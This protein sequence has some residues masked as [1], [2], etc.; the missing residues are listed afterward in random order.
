MIGLTSA[1]IFRTATAAPRA[2]RRH[3]LRH[4]RLVCALTLAPTQMT[5]LAATVAMAPPPARARLVPTARTAATG[6]MTHLPSLR[7]T[8][9]LRLRRRSCA[10]T[11][12]L[13][14][15]MGIAAMAASPPMAALTV[16]RRSA[17]MVRI[18]RTAVHACTLLRRRH[19]PNR[20]R[21]QRRLRLRLRQHRRPH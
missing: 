3:R 5:A 4:R 2:P 8:H 10:S 1:S 9:R 7:Q 13:T 14:Q 17:S 16:A 18:A 15:A 19:H 21:R 20:R 11:R 6:C 12:A